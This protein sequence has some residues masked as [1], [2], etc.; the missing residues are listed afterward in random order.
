MRRLNESLDGLT[1]SE[2]EAFVRQVIEE[3]R[4]AVRP[5]VRYLPP[6]FYTD[7]EESA[8]ETPRE[9]RDGNVILDTEDETTAFVNRDKDSRRR[10]KLP[11]DITMPSTSAKVNVTT[12]TES[13][14]AKRRRDSKDK[15]KK[16]TII[17]PIFVT[18]WQV[19]TSLLRTQRKYMSQIQRRPEAPKT[20]T[21]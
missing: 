7:E 6:N 19:T 11:G 13:S 1:S 16:V 5:G 17:K 8:E 20:Q 14:P 3:T 15:G 10:K 21:S 9:D 4:S 2:K 18:S 12:D